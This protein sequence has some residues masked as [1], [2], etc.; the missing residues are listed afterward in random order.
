MENDEDPSRQAALFVTT[1]EPTPVNFTIEIDQAY[2]ASM[3]NGIASYGRTTQVS[4]S[5]GS[6]ALSGADIRVRTHQTGINTDQSN[7]NIRVKAEDGKNIIVF[8]LTSQSVSTDAF[9]ALPC[10]SYNAITG[11]ARYE[12]F[13][14]SSTQRRAPFE[15]SDPPDLRSAFLIVT[16][17][18]DT[19]ITVLS[20]AVAFLRGSGSAVRINA[21]V[22]VPYTEATRR[23]TILVQSSARD[24]ELT[25]AIVTSNKPIS[26]FSGHQ[27]GRI[28]IDRTA[29]DHLMEQI[30]PHVVWGTT[31]FAVPLATRRSGDIFRVG[32]IRDNT[33]INV[34]CVTPGSSDPK[35]TMS[36]TRNRSPTPQ[37]N[38]YY[39]FDTGPPSRDSNFQA[40]YCC[41][42]TNKPVVVMQYSKGHSIDELPNSLGDPFMMLVPPVQQSF[43]N[44]TLSTLGLSTDYESSTSIAISAEFFSNSA[45][46]QAKVRL[47]SE[48]VTASSGSWTPIYCHNRLICGYGAQTG[49]ATGNS[50]LVF[51]DPLGGMNVYTYGFKREASYGYPGG[52]R[53]E[54]IGCKLKCQFLIILL[55]F[56]FSMA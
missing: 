5:T 46:D 1:D 45:A 50:T 47:N 41:I 40:D 11:A 3:S 56:V 55:I 36:A 22:A 38:N 14:F 12:Y 49:L 48:T 8:G 24:T 6:P 52:F 23:T 18:N 13:I 16:C 4:F 44:F 28:P 19:Q 32:A 51:N 54:P 10:H 15:I 29:C 53:M 42:E 39:E 2:G 25:G 21:G 43:N 17:Q 20:P 26:V 37:G 31:F 27:C 33:V 35:D 30:P 9:L 7:K 34:T